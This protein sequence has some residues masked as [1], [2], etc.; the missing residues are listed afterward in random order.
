MSP[1]LTSTLSSDFVGLFDWEEPHIACAD[2]WERLIRQACQALERVNDAYGPLVAVPEIG[3]RNGL[4]QVYVEAHDLERPRA[5]GMEAWARVLAIVDRARDTSAAVC[6]Y[7][8][9]PGQLQASAGHRIRVGCP[10]HLR[11]PW[12]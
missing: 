11:L 1:E 8:G 12:W 9:G 3:Y 7:C 2:G 10:E 6:E 4:L 5:V